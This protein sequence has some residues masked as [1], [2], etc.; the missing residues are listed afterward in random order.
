[1]NEYSNSNSAFEPQAPVRNIADLN[2]PISSEVYRSHEARALQDKPKNPGSGVIPYPKAG[3]LDNW[4]KDH[5]WFVVEN[6][7]DVRI[8]V[9][10]QNSL[11]A[12][13]EA[14]IRWIDNAGITLDQVITPVSRAGSSAIGWILIRANAKLR[15]F[16]RPRI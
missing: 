10:F 8:K 3:Q 2:L 11:I 13:H 9:I 14:V 12:A 16:A 7:D 1:M 6:L 5:F 15:V 4:Q